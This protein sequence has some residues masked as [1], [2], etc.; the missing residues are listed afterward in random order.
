[1]ANLITTRFDKEAQF[2][3]DIRSFRKLNIENVYV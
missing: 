3:F 2:N 1:M